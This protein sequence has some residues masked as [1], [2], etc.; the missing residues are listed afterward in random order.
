MRP[1]DANQKTK[2]IAELEQLWPQMAGVTPDSV[3]LSVPR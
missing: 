1:I 2:L 3:H